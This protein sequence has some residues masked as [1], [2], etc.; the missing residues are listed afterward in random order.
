MLA[1]LLL[2][3]AVA[4]GAVLATGGGNGAARHRTARK[5]SPPL[6][7]VPVAVLNATPTAGA[8]HQLAVQLQGDR[9]SVSTVG[10][11]VESRPPG[12]EVL[13]APDQLAQAQRVARLLSAHSPTVAPIDPVNAAAA[14]SS[15]R[16]V[17]VIT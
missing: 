11:V 5:P 3:G 6:P 14:G 4:A 8:A 7:T 15:A 13:Y 9:V 10:N 17:V 2:V 1:T 16:V 12:V